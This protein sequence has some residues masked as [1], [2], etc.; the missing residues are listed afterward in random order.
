MKRKDIA[1]GTALLASLSEPQAMLKAMA[2]LSHKHSEASDKIAEL[3]SKAKDMD[4]RE[5]A[6]NALMEDHRRQEAAITHREQE[7]NALFT[8]H[9]AEVQA[10][11]LA[12]IKQRDANNKDFAERAEQ[13]NVRENSL[14]EQSRK[15]VQERLAIDQFADKLKEREE[16]VTAR[17]EKWQHDY[18]ELLITKAKLRELVHE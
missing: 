4:V 1:A 5:A 3:E 13:Q 15:I 8:A 17:E 12:F 14:N 18:Q 6:L 10:T 7:L 11:K 9:H 16:A 2:E